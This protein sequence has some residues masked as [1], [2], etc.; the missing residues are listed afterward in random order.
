MKLCLL[1]LEL[2]EAAQTLTS[3]AGSPSKAKKKKDTAGEASKALSAA[4][5]SPSVSEDSKRVVFKTMVEL[6]RNLEMPSASFQEL[7]DAV[8]SKGIADHDQL[9][10]IVLALDHEGK[11][12]WRAEEQMVFLI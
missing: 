7:L 10:S 12:M 8:K 4:V 6:V 11:F 9:L 1:I 5:S 2:G 3:L